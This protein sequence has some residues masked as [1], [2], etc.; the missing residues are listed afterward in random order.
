MSSKVIRLLIEVILILIGA[1][2]LTNSDNEVIHRLSIGLI[3]AGFTSLV[4]ELIIKYDSKDKLEETKDILI[5]EIAE[6]KK[7]YRETETESKKEL[8]K[9]IKPTLRL[10][11]KRHNMDD[12]YKNLFLNVRSKFDLISLTSENFQRVCGEERLIINKIEEGCD[13]RILILDKNSQLWKYRFKSEP[14]MDKDKL[15]VIND[16]VEEKYRKIQSTLRVRTLRKKEPFTG[17]L[18]VRYYDDIPYYAYCRSDN[19]A[20][21]GFYY[22]FT[23]GMKSHAFSTKEESKYDN[24]EYSTSETD[25]LFK[26]LSLHFE[27]LWNKS[28]KEKEI[29]NINYRSLIEVE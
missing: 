12:F 27:N 11:D 17:S 22:S 6:F 8:K 20:I 16:K 7:E 1:F 25:N 10:I 14:N 23:V 3:T 13:V 2:T 21:L 28:T 18:I 5:N 4:V 19:Q 29:V 26:N 15:K 9:Y 24:S